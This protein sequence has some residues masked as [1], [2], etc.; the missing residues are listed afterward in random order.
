MLF[1]LKV[2][3]IAYQDSALKRLSKLYILQ[4]YFAVL[5]VR[6]LWASDKMFFVSDPIMVRVKY[7]RSKKVQLFYP[8]GQ[9]FHLSDTIQPKVQYICSRTAKCLISLPYLPICL[10][11]AI[12]DIRWTE[13]APGHRLQTGN[14]LPLLTY[15]IIQYLITHILIFLLITQYRT[16]IFFSPTRPSGPRWSESRHVH[17][18][19]CV[20]DVPFPY[21][22]FRP[23]IG[24]QVTWSDPCVSLAL[25]SPRTV[26]R[27]GGDWILHSSDNKNTKVST[28][29][30]TSTK[31]PLCTFWDISN[32]LPFWRTAL[33]QQLFQFIQ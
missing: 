23:L 30:T 12:S 28:I 3:K 1:G 17:V 10:L 8:S 16:N 24:P 6:L 27:R 32:V 11:Q 13:E 19:V 14:G 26:P 15:T 2:T 25:R 20:F 33:R 22:F 31:P 18:S 29:L 21:N 4:K 9:L 5:S 7:I